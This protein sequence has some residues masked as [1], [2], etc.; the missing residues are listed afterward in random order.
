MKHELRLQC[1][2]FI[3]A[4]VIFVSSCSAQ[5]KPAYNTKTWDRSADH[6]TNFCSRHE[7]LERGDIKL[8]DALKGLNISV[9]I[10]KYQM[11][12]ETGA[13][14]ASRPGIA[15]EILDEI[16]RTAGFTYRNNYGLVDAPST[17]SN[18]TYTDVQEY[19]TDTYDVIGEWYLETTFR[20]ERGMLFSEGWYNG[21]LI[22]VMK[23]KDGQD[24]NNVDLWAFMAPFTTLVWFMIG[25]LSIISGIIYYILDYFDSRL[26]KRKMDIGLEESLFYTA[27]SFNGHFV[28]QPKSRASRMMVFSIGFFYLLIVAAYT[29]N[30]AS[31]LVA[32]N[33]PTIVINDMKDGIANDY[34]FCVWGD[35]GMDE[36]LRTYN[37][38]KVRIHR[39]YTP[40][41][42]FNAVREDK[43]DIL[44]T[45]R[46]DWEKYRRSRTHNPDCSLEL[47]GR[48]VKFQSA[49]YS[50]RDSEQYC[51]SV[52]RN[53]FDL[54]ISKMKEVGL[55]ESMWDHYLGKEATNTCVEEEEATNEKDKTKIHTSMGIANLSGIFVMHLTALLLACM[56]TCFRVY[57]QPSRTKKA[58]F[59]EINRALRGHRGLTKAAASARFKKSM[60]VKDLE[61]STNHTKMSGNSSVLDGLMERGYQHKGNASSDVSLFFHESMNT[62]Q[63]EDNMSKITKDMDGARHQFVA[64]MEIRDDEHKYFMEDM[65]KQHQA[66][67]KTICRNHETEMEKLKQEILHTMKG[68]VQSNN[69][70]ISMLERRELYFE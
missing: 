59:A 4:I 47:V 9:A 43:C 34:S 42:E 6:R 25:A 31:F 5:E 57:Q 27:F 1:I 16:A 15:I 69:Q 62:T 46:S 23:K 33:R 24:D 40:G 11:N 54:H 66:E 67:M 45:T 49:G 21:N 65:C 64:E 60:C 63:K 26:K 28:H 37:I 12:P 3:L 53:A 44:L 70:D 30:L 19:A 48:I 51:T 7:A 18:Y 68:M 17:D 14:D 36:H 56:W 10:F 41:D 55:I 2:A 22:M 52:L 29:A 13:I 39:T 8:R 35:T 32:K 20:L 58:M 38:P 50:F 61:N